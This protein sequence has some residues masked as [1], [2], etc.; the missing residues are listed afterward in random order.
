MTRP[1]SAIVGATTPD[2]VVTIYRAFGFEVWGQQAIGAAAAAALYGLA[3]P[4]R[5][6]VMAP[7]GAPRG[8]LTIVE[9]PNEGP[10]P[11]PYDNGPHAIDLY[12]RDVN[13]SAAL[14]DAAG[15]PSGPVVRYQMGPFDVREVKTVGPDHLVSVFI[16]VQRRRPSVLDADPARLHS[17]VHSAVWTV[18][19]IDDVLPFWTEQAGLTLLLD[20]TAREPEVGR[21]M[22]LPRLD[23]PVRLVV[24]ADHTSAPIRLE[25]VEFPEES[26]GAFDTWPLRGGLHAI[27]LGV[28][29]LDVAMTA[30]PGARFGPV[31]MRPCG[32]SGGLV[33]AVAGLAP[34]GTRFELWETA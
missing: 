25:F 34:H 3:G 14:A 9:T 13:Q 2:A 5:Q 29:R 11:G 18:D 4:T 17:E 21:F 8:W 31:T 33:P 1:L 19:R 10:H 28:D 32:P 27:A 23:T 7:P 22:G 6:V 15:S 20:A 26:G 24:L 16:E 12:S 30:M